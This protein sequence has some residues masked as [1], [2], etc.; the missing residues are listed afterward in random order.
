MAGSAKTLLQATRS[1]W[2]IENSL[3]WS[4]DVTFR[5]DHSRVRKD[6]GPQNLA[7]LRQIALNLLKQETSLKRGLQG[8]RL[9]AGWVE[10]Y[11]LKVLLG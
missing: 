1:H 2:G 11:L 4:L 10:N 3:H 5:E 9:K 8:K 7:V 6:H